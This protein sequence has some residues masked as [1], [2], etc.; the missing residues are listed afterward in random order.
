MQNRISNRIS[1]IAAGQDG[2]NEAQPI[3]D[4]LKELLAQYEARFP[5]VRVTVVETAAMAV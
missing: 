5:E 2:R 3:G 1:E 4:I